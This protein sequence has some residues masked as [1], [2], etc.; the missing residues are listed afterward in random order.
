MQCFDTSYHPGF[1]IRILVGNGTLRV[2]HLPR[3][4]AFDEI[5]VYLKD[6]EGHSY[7][8]ERPAVRSGHNALTFPDAPDGLLSLEVFARCDAHTWEGYIY[9]ND[10]LLERSSGQMR[11]HQPRP[12]RHNKELLQ[13]LSR[14]PAFLRECLLPSER[15]RSDL[16]AVRQLAAS[17]TGSIRDP[18]ERA[19]VIYDWIVEHISYDADSVR[20]DSYDRDGQT[21]SALLSSKRGV[22][23]GVSDLYVSLLRAAG[24]P[25][26]SRAC[27]ALGQ[28][29][30]GGWERK[31]NTVSEANHD[32][33]VFHARGRWILTD[34]TWDLRKTYLDGELQDRVSE[35]LC[36]KHF[37]ISLPLL[38]AT[39]RFCN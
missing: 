1:N 22:C 24:I 28:G 2:D 3:G 37:D 23:C 39:H 25:A 30:S 13:G 16:P 6:A 15:C 36:H 26:L 11:F 12:Y 8:A 34:V 33:S 21:Q 19:L 31:T 17:L 14:G 27:Y 5:R 4:G 20:D 9:G 38:S 29:T 32:F 35:G 10:I 18:Y 7:P